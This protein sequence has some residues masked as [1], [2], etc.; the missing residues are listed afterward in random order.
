M[1][2]GDRLFTIRELADDCRNRT[3]AWL[4]CAEAEQ[5]RT[6]GDAGSSL[7]WLAGRYAVKRL[8]GELRPS[9][10]PFSDLHIESRDGR[11]RKVR[12]IAHLRGQLQPWSLSLAHTEK[13]VYVAAA[14]SPRLRVGVDVVEVD[15][16]VPG[17]IAFWFTPAEKDWCGK[18][19]HSAAFALVWSLKEAWYKAET[20][21]EPFAPRRLDVCGLLP[22]GA[23]IRKQLTGGW[24]YDAVVWERSGRHISIRRNRSAL[25]T[26]VVAG[27]DSRFRQFECFPDL[28]A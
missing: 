3:L 27:S 23:A 7:R 5:L 28:N 13:Y 10:D 18:I 19:G 12:P 15:S 24:P 2:W 1:R 4:S 14:L 17:A 21:G 8:L 26:L 20:S 16:V 25:A 6:F 9:R 11:G 22:H